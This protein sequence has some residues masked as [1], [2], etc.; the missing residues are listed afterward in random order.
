MAD[1]NSSP[2]VLQLLAARAGQEKVATM[3]RANR[4]MKSP[5]ALK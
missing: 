2:A 1:S 3:Q 4:C 5:N